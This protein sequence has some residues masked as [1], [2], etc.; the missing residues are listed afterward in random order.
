MNKA[1]R[2]KLSAIIDAL[3]VFRDKIEEIH[4][5]EES[6]LQ[7]MPESLEGSERYESLEEAVDNLSEAMDMFDDVIDCL[8]S[9]KE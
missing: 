7:N 8:N 1:R 2:Q 4:S 9:A 5:E 6:A 3:S